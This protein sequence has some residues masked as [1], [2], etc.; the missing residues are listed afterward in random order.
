M[1]A[2]AVTFAFAALLLCVLAGCSA[3]SPHDVAPAAPSAPTPTAPASTSEPTKEAP[4]VSTA[5]G[6]RPDT[7][8][9][10]KPGTETA[11]FAGG[12]FWCVEAVLEEI[13]GVLDVKSGYIG[14]TTPNPTYRE[15]CEGDTGHAEA[16]E[17]TFD[18]AQVTYGALLDWFWKA[19]DPT[20][21]NRQGADVGTQYRSA[22]FTHSD[23]QR[24]AA[25]ASKAAAQA[26]FEDPIVTE[27]TP[28]GVFTVAEGYHQDYYRLNKAQPY[29]RAVIAPK[30]QKL[31][32]EKK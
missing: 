19:H 28:A 12:C 14:G 27:I 26:R 1:R 15:V 18:P 11:T 13:P 5:P 24:A 29:C 20:T 3:G 10:S 6:Q 7:P 22:I 17:V 9:Q 21:K 32:I 8:A 25:E 16:V 2:L 23:V 4:A 31:G 30:L